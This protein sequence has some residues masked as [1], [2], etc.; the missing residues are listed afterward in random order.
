MEMGTSD[1]R[2]RVYVETRRLEFLYALK[3][4]EVGSELGIAI[5]RK[6]SLDVFL[7]EKQNDL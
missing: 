5:P 1:E 2:H 3:V 7:Y 6:I 4:H